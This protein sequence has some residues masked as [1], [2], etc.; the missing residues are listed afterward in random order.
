MSDSKIYGTRFETYYGSEYK[1][2]ERVL[3]TIPAQPGYT[4][5]RFHDNGPDETHWET[6]PVLYWLVMK[7]NPLQPWPCSIQEEW[8]PACIIVETPNSEC[9][10][11]GDGYVWSTVDEAKKY[12]E[13]RI[14]RD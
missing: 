12:I 4:I 13:A 2:G 1:A 9:F 14:K 7:D 10:Y 11:V 3:A 8:G 6:C 5:H